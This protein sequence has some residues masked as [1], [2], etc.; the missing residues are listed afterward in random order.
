M[1][2]QMTQETAKLNTEKEKLTEINKKLEEVI[3]NLVNAQ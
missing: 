1:I 2:S 3:E